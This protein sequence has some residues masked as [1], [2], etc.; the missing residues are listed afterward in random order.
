MTVVRFLAGRDEEL[1][2]DYLYLA[3]F[4]PRGHP[5]LSP[6]ILREPAAAQYVDGWGRDGDVGVVASESP[7]GYADVA[8]AS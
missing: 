4:V 3:L 8:D 6:D 7:S 5:P 1:L 2:R